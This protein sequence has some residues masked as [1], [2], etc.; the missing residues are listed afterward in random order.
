M[1]IATY[2]TKKYTYALPNFGRRLASALYQRKLKNAKVIFVG[3]ASVEIEEYAT[4]YIKNVL[5]RNIDFVLEQLSL[6][7]SQKENYKVDTQ[8]LIAQMQSHAFTL[9]RSYDAKQFWSLES[10]VLVPPNALSV[11]QDI[12]KFDHGYYDVAMCSY[13]SQGGGAYLGGRGDY[14]SYIFE[15][16]LENERSIPKELLQRKK[17]HL[18]IEDKNEA[19][20]EKMH[21]L[22]DEIKKCPP[23]NNVY[24]LNGKK[25]RRRGWMEYAYP[26]I[27]K[28]AIVPT[29]WVGLGCTL[30]SKKALAL[31][32][33]DGYEGKGTQDL[34]LGWHRWKPNGLN[35][36]VTSHAICD[37]VI[38]ERA[39]DAQQDYK[40]IKICNAYH[41]PDGEYE[42]HLRQ[43]IG[44]HYQFVAGEKPKD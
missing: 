13:P 44:E 18:Q 17:E 43:R 20:A 28:G 9:A 36:C 37:H 5:P 23:K 12:L 40:Q 15:D 25:W 3:D 35:M 33:F 31:A 19:W 29:D 2:A 11:S 1:I 7:D 42:G 21:E 41:Q 16:F 39:G 24:A 10:D 38:R 30:L 26:S 34:Y 32:H 14:W 4:K 8:L 27:G 6:E 22:S